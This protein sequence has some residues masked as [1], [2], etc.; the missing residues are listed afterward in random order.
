MADW[1][2]E[3]S[4]T[5]AEVLREV[6]RTNELVK[7]ITQENRR[8]TETLIVA[9]REHSAYVRQHLSQHEARITRLE[10]NQPNA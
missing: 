5:L 3:L 1:N 6:D 7:T 4:I 8:N 10:N 9:F 2:D